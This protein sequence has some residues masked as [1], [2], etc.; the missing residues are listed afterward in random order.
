M[1]LK[2]IPIQRKM[3]IILLLIS[4]I[5]MVLMRSTFF[6]YE[7]Y[8][9]RQTTARQLSTLG[10]VIA[11]NSTAALAFDNRDDASDTLS[12]LQAEPH[13][14]A[15]ALYDTDG[16]LFSQYPTNLKTN[17][18]PPVIGA[19]GYK[20]VD[21][22]LLLF[23]SVNRG[24]K[25]LGTLY[26]ELDTKTVMHEWL[27]AMIGIAVAVMTL[28]LLLVY[29]VSRSLQ[30]Q[31]SQP[32]LSLAETA[33]TISIDQ[34]Y[35]VRAVKAGN[36]EI[37]LLTDAFN[38]MLTRI[39]E[40]NGKLRDSERRFRALIEHSADSIAVIS[41]DNKI[42]YLSP[43]VTKV[44]GYSSEE[45]IGRNGLDNTHPDDV[46]HVEECVRQLL[47]F[48]G[49][50]IPVVWRRQHKDGR[51][52]WLEGVATNLLDDP[53]INGIV[54]NY[55]DITERK[56]AEEKAAREQERFKLIFDTV[57]VGITLTTKQSDGQV[58]RI[59]NDALLRISGLSREEDAQP[60]IYRRLRHPDES[61]RQ[62][63]L[64]AQVEAGKL[65]EF[66]MEKRYLRLDGTVAWAV[67]SL[68]RRTF[69]DG[70]SE[71][72]TTV[73]DITERK[74][75]EEAVR[76]SETRYRILFDTMIEGFC[77]I[78]VLFD[79]AGK[80]VDYRFLEINPAFERQTGMHNAQGRLM[81]DLAPELEESWFQIFGKVAQ[82][83]EPVHF[84]NEAR[85]L[86][87]FYYVS[88]YRIGGPGSRKVGILF[89]DITKRKQDEA[90]IKKLNSTLE[91]RVRDRTTQLEAA[92]KE[93]EAFSYSVSHDLRAPL[94]HIGG[95]ADLL[96]QTS[97]NSLS[98]SGQRYL[99]IIAE[100]AKKMGLL[101][102][103]LLVF[104]RMGRTEMRQTNVKTDA[105]VAEVLAEMDRDLEG[106][107]IIWNIK[108]LPDVQG[109]RAMLKQVWVNLLSNA[110]KYTRHREPAIIEV[111][112]SGDH[113]GDRVFSVKDNGAG[114]DMQFVGKLFGVFQRLHRPEEFEGTGV[115]LAN[116]QR[117]I[118][119]H[120][121]R[122]W[123]EGAVDA[124]ATF[125]FSLP[126]QTKS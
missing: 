76:E 109:D 84:E 34:D 56:Y 32:I 101:I 110:V 117:I 75:A 33:R 23:K 45:L 120:G 87:R 118:H 80:P 48:P 4:V 104:S 111:T 81:R 1:R 38:L 99:N 14:V 59:I 98:E 53:A 50:P 39:H 83:G 88:A 108:P 47:Q 22:K 52:L 91:Q 74:Q 61:P 102:D 49:R 116:V 71:E 31:I 26:L 114:F 112:S 29:F 46:A 27:L 2:D 17:T 63:E 78:E 58:S 6:L 82:T 106:R 121:G 96:R 19:D 24:G 5:V 11:A 119:R 100:A 85:A 90:E 86:G 105:L 73:V 70:R 125:Y 68:Q 67:F 65:S 55:R 57:P 8:T 62:D 40:Q 103:D 94:R 12:A 89:N 93:L 20:F 10:E 77:T 126:N 66:S 107:K 42:T 25:Q 21:G 28:V 30:K 54:T 123:A 44:E 79:D 41:A 95:F 7:F 69:E 36:D 13:I 72:L 3:M 37:G 97:M 64:Y 43:S 51:W 124:G 9:F 122:V 15:A 113:G 35:S 18:L 115:G 60:G 16:K 92:N